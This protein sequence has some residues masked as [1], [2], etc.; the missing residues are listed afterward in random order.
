[1]KCVIFD[2]DG[3]LTQSEEG[4]INCVKYAAEKLNWPLPDEETLHKFIGPPLQYGFMEY[5]GRTKEEAEAGVEA[6]RER[7]NDIGLFENRVYPGIRRLLRMLKQQGCY[8]GVATGKPEEPSRRI[9]AKF[10]L[11]KYLDAIVGP[12]PSDL[13]DKKRLIQKALPETYDEAWMVGDRCFDIAGAKAVGIGSIGVGYGYGT[14][15]ELEEAGC[16]V[17]VDTVQQ[18]IDT[19]CPNQPVP[20]GAFLTMEGPDG[21]G[22]T[23]QMKYLVDNLSRYGFEVRPTREPGGCGIAE[24]IRRVLLDLENKSMEPVTEALLF[25]AARAQHVRRGRWWCLTD[26]WTPP[27]PIRAADGCW[28]CRRCW[29]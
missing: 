7:Y 10:K 18:L 22:K 5:M 4:I 15:Q 29:T 24:S 21:S 16:D 2:L 27:W 11:D 12:A 8:L 9:L 26:S 23:T 14:R 6:Y 20:K 17:Y 28:G 25:A 13:A 19:L 1:M 3:T